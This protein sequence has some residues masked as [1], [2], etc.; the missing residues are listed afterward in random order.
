MDVAAVV[1]PGP[2]RGVP[3]RR[4]GLRPRRVLGPGARARRAR[5]S[6]ATSPSRASGRSS[7]AG[8]TTRAASSRTSATGSGSPSSSEFV[9]DSPAAAIAG[10]LMGC[11]AG[12]VLPRPR[13]RQGAGHDAA[14]PVAPGSALLQRRG[15][16]DVLGVA[17]GRPGLAR[18]D[19]RVRRRLAP[20]PVADAAHVHGQPGEVVPGG[21]RSRIC[22]TSRPTAPPSRSSA[23]SSSPATRS[24]S[25]C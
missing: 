15:R 20:R 23:G 21:Q 11:R 12:A 9:R 7:R 25:T 19:A 5:R 14:T 18:G 4:R 13:A 17:A 10:E 6:S 24:S 8:P 22:P 3:A 2:R 16:A 1:D